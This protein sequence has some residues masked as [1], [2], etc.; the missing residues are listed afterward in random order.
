MHI[1]AGKLKSKRLYTLKSIRVVEARV[2]KVLCSILKDHI[3]GASVLDLF[4]GTG[5]LGIEALSWGAYR[6]VF[7]DIKKSSLNVVRKN[8]SSLGL[9]GSSELYLKDAL[10]A[11]R[12]FHGLQRKFDMILLDPPYHSGLLTKALKTLG[13]YDIVEPS[14]LIV[15]LGSYKEEAKKERFYCIFDRRYGDRRVKILTPQDG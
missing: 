9:L 5:S 7:V 2:K 12:K 3:S 1:L 15:S 8:L 6:A 4:A 14:G 11:C 13:A 10:L